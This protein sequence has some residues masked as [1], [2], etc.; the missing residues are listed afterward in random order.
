VPAGI[1]VATGKSTGAIAI[2]TRPVTAPT[3]V[4]ITA[5]LGGVSK[6]FTLTLTPAALNYLYDYAKSVA[7]GQAV[8]E[9]FALTAPAASGA[10]LTLV[11]SNPAAVSVP[12]SIALTANQQTGTMTMQTSPVAAMTV[13][14]ITA[15]L[16]GV[17]KVF[18]LTVM[19]AALN[20]LYD[21]AKS[22]AGGQAVSEQFAL[23]A[24]AASG[25]AL[26]LVSSNP[27]VASVPASIAL[28]VGQQT[29]TIT[30][31]TSPVA[32]QTV[33]TITASLGGVSK[34]FT[35]TVMPA[36]LNYLYDYAKSVA[37]GQAVSEQFALTAP[38]STGAM[39]ALVSS[40]PTAVSVPASIALT[41]S[42][43]TGTITMQTSPVATLTVV[44]ITA[45]LG[46]VS[47]VFTLTVTPAALNYL[48]E[49]AKTVVG[50]QS[51]SEPFTLTAP[52]A[53]GATLTLVSSNPGVASVPP[54]VTIAAGKSSGTI[55]IQTTPVKVQT[56]ITI[57]ASC[58][59]VTK[60]LT[61]TV[62]PAVAKY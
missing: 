9:Q 61:L 47:K 13:V 59:G 23:T 31:Q 27:S 6:V 15:S 2:Q 36:A 33:V 62:N 45:S 19:P 12:S 20:Y 41:A 5:S 34:V 7:G 48:N 39:L 30:M 58:G 55:V 14:T 60:V 57:T 32:A 10:A 43:Q 18:T 56:M 53:N 51:V 8:S 26:T 40:N 29:G 37:G 3:A 22:V 24:P 42:Q 11:S 4:T 17:S 1:A 46:G 52:A 28:T 54:T 38:A 49:Y 21:Y 35:L 44:T 25:A 50:G 16:G